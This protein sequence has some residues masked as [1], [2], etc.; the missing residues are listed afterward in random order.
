MVNIKEILSYI[1]SHK[2][3]YLK[4]KER[5]GYSTV[6]ISAVLNGKKK[7]TVQFAKLLALALKEAVQESQEIKL[8]NKEKKCKK[9]LYMQPTF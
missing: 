6:H 9:P 5:T 3:P 4:L 7:C 2:I 8:F 1:K